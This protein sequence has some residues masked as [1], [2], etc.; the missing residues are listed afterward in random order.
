[1]IDPIQRTIIV[2][3][4]RARAF[5]VFT[6]EMGSWWPLDTFSRAVDEGGAPVVAI[7]FDHEV[8]TIWEVRADGG[9]ASWG[10]IL[11]WEPPTRLVMAWKP[12]DRPVEPTEVEVTFTALEE[13]GTRV[14]LEHRGWERLGDLAA[15]G[16]E[17]YASGWPMVFD[18]RFANAAN[19]VAA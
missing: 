11:V 8:G 6:D 5:R 7:A 2:R 1:M 13:G 10:E 15:Q 12:R 9:R 17:N 4:D 14:D 3:C 19:A 18:Q 16:R